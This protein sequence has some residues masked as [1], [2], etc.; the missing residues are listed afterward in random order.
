MLPAIPYALGLGVMYLWGF[1]IG[2]VAIQQT[3]ADLKQSQT[4]VEQFNADSNGSYGDVRDN[5]DYIGDRWV[6]RPGI[7]EIPIQH[8]MTTEQY[9]KEM[10]K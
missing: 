4:Q 8:P 7:K 3:A 6:I 1:M 5:F 10:S 9:I 2:G